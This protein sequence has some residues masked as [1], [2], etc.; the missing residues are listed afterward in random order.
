VNHR[1]RENHA[2]QS[3][4]LLW[5]TQCVTG[6]SFLET[7]GSS[8]VTSAHFLDFFTLIGVH[9]QDATETLFRPLTGLYSIAGIDHAGIDTEEDQ[10][11]DE[12]IG[13]DLECQ[14][15]ERFVISGATLAFGF[16]LE[17]LTGGI[18]TGDGSSR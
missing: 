5:V 15:G 17:P 9:L 11:T 7:D 6:G 12:R 10:L 14:S 4:N 16:I 8:D 13:H 3:D 18:S 1:L 2:F